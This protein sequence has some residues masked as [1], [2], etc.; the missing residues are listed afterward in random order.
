MEFTAAELLTGIIAI[1]GIGVTV[2]IAFT[3]Q[4]PTLRAYKIFCKIAHLTLPE[5]VNILIN[6]KGERKA[7]DLLTLTILKNTNKK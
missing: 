7:T 3:K 6:D 4:Q 5:R 1:F 2:G